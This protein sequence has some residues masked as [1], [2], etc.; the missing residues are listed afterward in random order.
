MV[1]VYPETLRVWIVQALQQNILPAGHHT[2]LAR[3]V[4][5]VDDQLGPRRDEGDALERGSFGQQCRRRGRRSRIRPSAPWSVHLV[6]VVQAVLAEELQLEPRQLLVQP[7]KTI[8]IAAP[9]G[10]GWPF[11]RFWRSRWPAR[12]VLKYQL[13]DIC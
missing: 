10:P 1:D 6:A 2:R 9:S 7:D 5:A 12:R 4:V 3:G 8:F 11:T 13:S